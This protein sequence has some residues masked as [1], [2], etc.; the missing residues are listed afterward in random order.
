MVEKTLPNG[1]V[2]PVRRRIVITRYH[3]INK[4]PSEVDPNEPLTEIEEVDVDEDFPDDDK[5]DPK[6]SN[7]Y[8][9]I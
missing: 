1:E 4:K 6:V 5:F 3:V 2:I 8:N 9:L 7:V